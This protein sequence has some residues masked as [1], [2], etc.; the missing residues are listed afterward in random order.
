MNYRYLSIFLLLA[1]ITLLSTSCE[2]EPDGDVVE[3]S[4]IEVRFRALIDGQPMVLNERYDYNGKDFTISS[5]KFYISDLVLV[6]GALE[7]NVK[8][9][10]FVDFGTSNTTAQGAADGVVV[11]GA[12]IPLGTYDGLK[13]GLGVP[14]DLN[15]ED[16]TDFSSNHPLGADSEYWLAWDSYIFHKVE[17]R[18]DGDN[19]ANDLESSYVYHVGLD[20]NFR[21][22]TF[23]NLEIEIAED[24]TAQVVIDI[25]VRDLMREANGNAFDFEAVGNIHSATGDGSYPGLIADNWV[26]A[27]SL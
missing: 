26:N 22:K 12:S 6:K 17:G 2:K 13:F 11:G 3:S 19:N 4:N 18:Y 5:L 16:P 7:A 27:F 1:S 24:N 8:E 15:N 20:E 14:S 25:E 23:S 21:E 10:D 9:I